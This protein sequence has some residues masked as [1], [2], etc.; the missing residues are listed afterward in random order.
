[1]SNAI[2][3]NS[4]GG[5]IR[6]IAQ[7]RGDEFVLQVCDTGP[8]IP[9]ESLEHIFEKF[10]RVPGAERMAQG[11]G[12]GLSICKRIVDAHSGRMEVQSKVGQG[13]IFVVTLPLKN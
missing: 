1:L 12:L 8:G 9:K 11:T 2:K 13:T 4:P 5:Q 7:A 3:Y 10:Y 6:L